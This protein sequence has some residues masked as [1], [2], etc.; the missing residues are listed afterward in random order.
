[1]RGD[2]WSQVAEMALALPEVTEGVRHGARTWFVAGKGFAWECGYSKADVK[3]AE[4]A[5]ESL[6]PPPNLAIDVGDLEEKEALLA[7]HAGDG[8]FTIPH[9]DR[10]PMLLIDLRRAPKR[11]VRDA[12]TDAWLGKAPP[13]LAQ[14]HSLGT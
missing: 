13:S 3:R 4:E 12:L 9:F 5:G 11:A 6:P 8:F 1:M 2:V 14:V 10:Y 7:A